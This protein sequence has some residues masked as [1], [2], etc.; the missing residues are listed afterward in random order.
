M[1]RARSSNLKV[2]L[3]MIDMTPN[4]SEKQLFLE[5]WQGEGFD[6]IT[7]KDFHVWAN[8]DEQF[9]QITQSQPP[10]PTCLSLRALD[11]LHRA[12]GRHRSSLLQR[13]CRQ[14]AARRS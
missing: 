9:I 2:A 1:K 6:S 13:L 12:G 14:N 7:I 5:Q 4:H 8:Q 3:Q 10:T 11:W